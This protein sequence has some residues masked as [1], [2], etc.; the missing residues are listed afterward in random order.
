LFNLYLHRLDRRL[1]SVPGGFYARYSD[2]ILFAHPNPVRAV[3]AD[4]AIRS[5][6]ARLGLRLKEAKSRDVFLNQAARPSR[7]PSG[8]IGCASVAFLGLD[9]HADGTIGLGREAAR[10]LLRDLADRAER[11]ARA[12][13]ASSRDKRGRAVC[14]V[15]NRVL[16]SEPA[17]LRQRSTDILRRLA[18]N[19]P[20]LRQLDYRIALLALR[21]ATGIS[22]PR[23]FRTVPYGRL[24]HDWGLG[25]LF[26][27]RNL[28]RRR[29]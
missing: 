3:E 18:T 24:R 9:V 10:S 28:G 8:F 22:G 23:A 12:T 11:T 5:E 20:Q 29:S 6:A 17:P 27:E 26:H 25:S 7:K 19:R 2:D 14:S 16:R 1:E 4:D 21:A 13:L 15:L